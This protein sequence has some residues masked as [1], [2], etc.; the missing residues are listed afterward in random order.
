MAVAIAEIIAVEEALDAAT[1]RIVELCASLSSFNAELLASCISALKPLLGREH[2]GGIAGFQVGYARVHGLSKA[3]IVAL[4][5]ARS[6]QL[7]D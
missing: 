5:A 1:A 4:L 2:V 7:H 6:L 3:R